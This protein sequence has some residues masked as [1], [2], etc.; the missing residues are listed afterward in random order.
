MENLEI[1]GDHLAPPAPLNIQEELAENLG[2]RADGAEGPSENSETKIE[3]PIT[4]DSLKTDLANKT[5]EIYHGPLSPK[6]KA[7]TMTDSLKM[8]A[9]LG[10]GIG[11]LSRVRAIIV[12]GTVVSRI[13]ACVREAKLEGGWEGYMGNFSPIKKRTIQNWLYIANNPQLHPYAWMGED[14]LLKVSRYAKK[15]YDGEDPI[16]AFLKDIGV[17]PVP[18]GTCVS[19]E[20]KKRIDDA[21]AKPR[22]ELSENPEVA[23]TTVPDQQADE[24]IDRLI[25]SLAD[26]NFLAKVDVTRL[27]TLAAK[28]DEA[29]A[30]LAEMS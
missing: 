9:D 29:K 24:L 25:E 11:D 8:Y 3:G 28:I 19:M 30:K 12:Y 17:D 16:G 13:R 10:L 1:G 5:A 27:D 14:R 2:E 26:D 21:I 15:N 7:L 6:E 18:D 23:V 4:E 22:S 20:V